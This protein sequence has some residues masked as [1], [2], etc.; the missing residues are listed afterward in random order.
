MTEIPME[1]DPGLG[2][3]DQVGLRM[4]C[5]NDMQ[6]EAVHRTLRTQFPGTSTLM[7]SFHPD[8]SHFVYVQANETAVRNKWPS[9]EAMVIGTSVVASGPAQVSRPVTKAAQ[10]QTSRS[11][12]RAPQGQQLE[13]LLAWRH[14]FREVVRQ[15]HDDIPASSAP[16][17]EVTLSWV[18]QQIQAGRA[19]EVEALLLQ[20]NLIS[21]S[22]ALRAQ[23]ALYSRTEQVEK[24]VALYEARRD[25]VLG[26]PVSGML[27]EQ[28]ISAYI[29]F[30]RESEAQDA[31]R[32]AQQIAQTLLP[33]LERLRQAAG[34]RQLL[35]KTFTSPEPAQAAVLPLSEEL[36]Q[37]VQIQ[38]GLQ[39]ERLKE[40]QRHHPQTLSIPLALAAAYEADGLTDQALETY[41]T[42]PTVTPEDQ[43]EVLLRSATLLLEAGRYYDVIERIPQVNASSALDGLRGAALFYLGQ[44]ETA[45]PY[46]ERAW[47]GGVCEQHVLLALARLRTSSGDLERGAEP[48]RRLLDVAD[49]LLNADDYAEI[50]TVAYFGGFGDLPT[51]Q[52]VSYCD[53][54]VRRAGAQ[55]HTLART[56]EILHL[57]TQQRESLG[58][59][60]LLQEAYADWLEYLADSGAVDALNKVFAELEGL[61]RRQKIS[62]EQRF[63]LLEMIE[64]H[65]G[66]L[67]SLRLALVNEYQHIAV[68][69]LERTLRHNQPLP[70]YLHDL[71]R[72]LHFL[73]RDYADFVSEY[74][75]EQRRA[76]DERGQ[77]V[78]GEPIEA[79]PVL[80]LSAVR[81][82][83]VGGHIATRREV[84][85]S[86]R[87]NYGLVHF[88]EVAPSSEDH[89]DR[90]RVLE[91]VGESDIIAVITGYT[92]HDLTT[93]VRDLQQNDKIQGRVL[94][95]KSRGKSGVVR[96]IITF[97]S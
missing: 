34:V 37:I 97:I 17:Q 26:L 56:E 35:Q 25:E 22:S 20:P 11:G 53:E 8:Y 95:L 32:T 28:L 75:D 15:I 85:R 59:S 49:A 13:D 44:R 72:A 18:E 70:V 41:R 84:E 6:A 90:G 67:D 50:C 38:P 7:R 29:Q 91:R 68:S 71:K 23:I 62:N 3:T 1:I 89:V 47:N 57:R 96:E 54:Y 5:L 81:L 52:I 33:E 69:E 66:R 82:A 21:P 46:L 94:W 31:L 4:R 79:E 88:A 24:V 83:L 78:P 10:G 55:L 45:R 36:A 14:R 92:G 64:P 9:I 12:T 42:A 80:D 61:S 43:A 86:L 77:Q 58:D 39:I 48:Y 74:I 76:L 65:A 16:T 51:E 40:L 30:A 73:D 27:A 93:I 63:N 19:A 2:K 60:T 87:E